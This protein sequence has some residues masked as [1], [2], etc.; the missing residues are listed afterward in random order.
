MLSY[1]QYTVDLHFAVPLNA[2]LNNG[3]ISLLWSAFKCSLVLL[4][5]QKLSK[6]ANVTQTLIVD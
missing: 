2:T 3:H 6:K 5:K 4:L 1:M